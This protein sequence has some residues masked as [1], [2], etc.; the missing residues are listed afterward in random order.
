[1]SEWGGR[2]GVGGREEG[3]EC[4]SVRVCVCVSEAGL[5]PSATWNEL[6]SV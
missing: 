2:E 5:E 6:V 3:R 1:M 4:V